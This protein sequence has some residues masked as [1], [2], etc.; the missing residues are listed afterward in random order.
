ME[1]RTSASDSLP[2]TAPPPAE[3]DPPLLAFS[4][5]ALPPLPPILSPRLEHLARQNGSAPASRQPGQAIGSNAEL[6]W[7]GD[8]VLG[9]LA[10]AQLRKLFPESSS[11]ML[12]KIRQRFLANRTLAHLTWA[13]TLPQQLSILQGS[14]ADALRQQRTAANSFEAYLGAV[15]ESQPDNLSVLYFF[16]GALL[17]PAVFPPLAEL[18]FLL[19]DN[20]ESV[21]LDPTSQKL[22]LEA[23]LGPTTDARAGGPGGP[24]RVTKHATHSW[25]DKFGGGASWT[26]T[27]TVHDRVVASGQASKIVDARDNALAA[28][29]AVRKGET[30]RAD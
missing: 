9:M 19:H 3:W 27:L 10:S 6:E 4:P 7:V 21:E 11:G 2:S 23:A 17:S 13:Y 20:G 28:Y 5:A 24:A 16:C 26:S 15:F 1:T 25:E 18:N 8:A 12:A 30:G 22:K 14:R 29:L